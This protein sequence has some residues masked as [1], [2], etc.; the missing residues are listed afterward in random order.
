MRFG[1]S[2]VAGMTPPERTQWE[3]QP[4]ERR[5]PA[6]WR[7]T[8]KCSTPTSWATFSRS[9]LQTGK[10]IW[11][12]AAF[13]NIDVPAA[14][15]QARMID[16]ARFA[17]L[18][19][20]EYVWSLGRDLKDPNQMAPFQLTCRRADGGDVVWQ[21]TELARL[22]P[23]R[24]GRHADPR[25]RDDLRRR[26]DADES[27]AAGPAA[28]VRPG[29]P[30]PTMASCSGRPRSGRSGRGQQYFYYGMRRHVASAEAAPRRGVGLRRHAR[31]RPRAA[32]RGV[33]GARL[34]LRLSDRA[35][36]DGRPVLLLRDD[37]AA[38]SRRS[39]SVPVRSG[40]AL[41]VKGARS[42][43]ICALDPDRM[44]L[45]WDRPIA[46]SARLLGAD[47]RAVFL[48]GPEISALGPQDADAALGDPPAGRERRG[49]VLVRPGGIWQLTPRGIFEID[50]RSG[51]VRRIFRGDDTGRGRRRPVPEPDACC[52]RS[53]TAPSRH[54][55]IGA[56]PRPAG[57]ATVSETRPD[58]R[59][60]GSS[61]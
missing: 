8:A 46:K 55:P 2:I 16:P 59:R 6:P 28:P 54:T 57:P 60:R 61:R 20:Q 39:S 58:H 43:R 48:G 35:R 44:K 33:R 41:F 13:H 3:T 34:G 40:D 29:D 22:R 49:R 36:P 47:D 7:S 9:S 37:A 14:Q 52:W 56:R 50:P 27:A 26:Q 30:A 53:P 12:S 4:P 31:R 25:R 10:L 51:R 5:R 19:S 18:A 24:P 38:R 15:D 17:I 42:E 23:A 45:L 11:R 21:S 32:R 1:E